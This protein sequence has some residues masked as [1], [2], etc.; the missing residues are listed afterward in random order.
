[1]FRNTNIKGPMK[2][3]LFALNLKVYFLKCM[4]PKFERPMIIVKIFDF[5]SVLS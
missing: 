2:R 3:K 4:I 5:I 1:M